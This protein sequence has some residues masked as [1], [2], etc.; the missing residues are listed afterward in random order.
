MCEFPLSI[1]L[2]LKCSLLKKQTNKKTNHN[3]A[4]FWRLS[5]EFQSTLGRMSLRSV[6]RQWSETLCQINKNKNNNKE[7]QSLQEHKHESELNLLL[8]K[9][10]INFSSSLTLLHGKQSAQEGK[11]RLMW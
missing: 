10:M 2:I 6:W 11:L 7:K 9:G 1:V 5:Y 8:I 3:C 4:T